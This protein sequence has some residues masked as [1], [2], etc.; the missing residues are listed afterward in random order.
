MNGGDRL[1]R[2][3]SE[4]ADDQGQ[5][6][7][8]HDSARQFFRQHIQQMQDD[9]KYMLPSGKIFGDIFFEHLQEKGWAFISQTSLSSFAINWEKH[10]SLIKKWSSDEH[11]IIAKDIIR[12]LPELPDSLLQL[13]MQFNTQDTRQFDMYRS[14][15]LDDTSQFT[16]EDLS[17]R[18]WLLLCL[19]KSVQ[20][21]RGGHLKMN[22]HSEHYY[23][24]HIWSLVFDTVLQ[25]IGG[26][27]LWRYVSRRWFAGT[28]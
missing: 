1:K 15:L 28:D 10:G 17:Y 25:S 6:I 4:L 5:Y 13:I 8:Q 16:E 23:S 12:P 18:E 27:R 20:L 22:D 14:R 24:A 21:T 26:A 19:T 2:P 7:P 3:Y 9:R 11:K